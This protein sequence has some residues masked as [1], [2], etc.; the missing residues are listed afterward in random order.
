MFSDIRAESV[1]MKPSVAAVWCD[2]EKKKREQD[3]LPVHNNLKV[4]YF[5]VTSGDDIHPTS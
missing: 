4:G 3:C 1:E 5:L 2:L